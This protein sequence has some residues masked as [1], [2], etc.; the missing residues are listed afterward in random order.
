MVKKIVA[1][2]SS[3]EHL[4]EICD[5]VF[6]L[7]AASVVHSVILHKP[8]S[9]DGAFIVNAASLA[10]LMEQRCQSLK[11]LTLHNLEMDE[12]HCRVLGVYSRPGLEITLNRC[13]LTSAGASALAEV[14]GRN[15][16][17]T[18]LDFCD[19]D[20]SVLADGLCGNSRL[21]S[22]NP[23]FSG[24]PEG[25]KRDAFAIAR[26]LPENRGLVDL[27]L[28]W[29]TTSNDTCND[30]WD[31]VCDSLKTHPTLE[32]LNLSAIF[33]T[34]AVLTS[35]VQ[36]LLDMMKVNMSIHT[37]RLSHHYSEHELFQGS[38]I[39]YLETNRLRQRFHAIQKNSP[40]CVPCQG[41]MVR[42][43]L[44]AR[45]NANS[46]WILLSGNAE[47]AFLSTTTTT[48][49]LPTPAT[50][51][52]TAAATSNADAVAAAVANVAT[53]TACQKRKTCR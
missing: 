18:E 16:G 32:V 53:P 23:D 30:T 4:S 43:L 45:T 40:N 47:V 17:P 10:Y 33:N 8:I 7:L 37:I 19:T 6:R 1:S 24:C 42:A 13:K 29:S 11:A 39:P 41:A 22:F 51:A 46:F 35:R 21:K 28:S 12:N 3:P 48:T 34:A 2:A 9:R 27:D 31:A 38:V 25:S 36:A 50:A 49:N 52:A 44:S 20:N 15:Q 5:V 26:A 14:L